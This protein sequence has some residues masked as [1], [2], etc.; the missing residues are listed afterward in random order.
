MAQRKTQSPAVR[1]LMMS[2]GSMYA[3]IYCLL[4]S[5]ELTSMPIFGGALYLC[6][7][8][9]SD[10]FTT[11]LGAR[12]ALLPRAMRKARTVILIAVLVVN[13]FLIVIYPLQFLSYQLWS[14]T[15]VVVSM[16]MRDMLA[17]RLVRQSANG[18]LRDTWFYVL[19]GAAH[20]LPALFVMW[21]FLQNL[22]VHRA[23]LL[24]AAYM[25]A[26]ILS[27][28]LHHKDREF[29]EEPRQARAQAELLQEKLEATYAFRSYEALSYAV[30]IGLTISTVL[31]YTYLIVNAQVM[32]LQMAVALVITFLVRE[33]AEGILRW[34]IRRRGKASDPTYVML[35]G[36]VLV[37]CG[38]WAFLQM[39]R[40]GKVH[41][42]DLLSTYISLIFCT[43]GDT[44]CIT[45]LGWMERAMGSVARFSAG[46]ETAGYR[47]IRSSQLQLSI[48]LGQMAA[49]L[50]LTLLCYLDGRQN[51]QSLG[52]L[53]SRI[54]PLL[55]VP[56]LLMILIGIICTLRFPLSRRFMDKLNRYLHLQ[57][58]GKTNKA[59]EKQ[60]E[61]VV[62]QKHR[63]PFGTSF[64]KAV[65]RLVYRHSLI[66]TDN[67]KLDDE[68]PLVF[69][70]N[71]G[72]IY[73]PVVCAS[74]IPV[75]IRPWVISQICN[76]VSETAEYHYKYDL[77]ENHL[78][79]EKLKM[80]LARIVGRIS[81][82][83]M[84]QLEAIPVYRDSP[85][86][87]V[88]TF[89]ESV[90]AL[91]S[92]DNLL[93]FPENP[94]A[95]SKDH[96]YEM[97]GLGPLFEG[98]TM[99][100]PIYYRRTGKALRLLP[101]YAHKKTRT[102]CF[103]QEV[104]YIPGTE[105]DEAERRRLVHACETEMLRLMKQQDESMDASRH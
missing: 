44:L 95:I 39:F 2:L 17:R 79:P 28:Y 59:L 94:N 105:D 49:L 53:I 54:Q 5:N 52:E 103:G 45:G 48:L 66:G 50:A 38:L 36:L 62:V 10:F 4:A 26:D 104:D 34:R 102:L 63:Q 13:L 20:I 40:S 1:I 25:I 30:V 71:H 70:C 57:D 16:Q 46:N 90:E 41:S 27:L 72:D 23:W 77:A 101:M 19:L 51:F 64:I 78:I 7:Q 93:I 83:C 18:R 100:A 56:A 22:P 89:R 86:L 74:S 80:P 73:G 14:V 43:A 88:R 60:L 37:L 92:G 9:A 81:V 76:D 24:F 42:H 6:S 15:L 33:A 68:N 82:W 65:A 85:A 75:P 32:I 99:L 12:G 3:Y 8:V 87:L 47:L 84:H 31:I 35:V 21:D 29:W 61:G 96:G 67:L 97:S 69:L 98:F 58:D 91:Q 55:I 11:C